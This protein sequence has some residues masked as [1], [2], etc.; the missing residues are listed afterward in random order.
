MS[1]HA[2]DLDRYLRILAGASPAGRLIEIRSATPHGGMRQTFTPAT[3]PDLAAQDDQ[4]ARQ[5]APTC[6]SA[7]CSA[8]AA[9]AA[10]RLRALPPRVRRD[11]PTRRR[12]SG[13]RNT[14]A[15]RAW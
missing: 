7:C 14:A 2:G 1:D 12:S 4:Q 11:R 8:A 15:R 5:P 13:S 10:A 9:P 6:T 3:R